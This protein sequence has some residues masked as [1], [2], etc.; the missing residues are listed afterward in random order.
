MSTQEI[1]QLRQAGRLD[2]AYA[3]AVAE[4]NAEPE[5]IWPKRNLS[6]VLYNQLDSL[7]K[8]LPKFLAKLEEL[9]ALDLPHDEV[10]FFENLSI[11]L[12]KSA[13]HIASQ[14]TVN[15]TDV[16]LLFNQIRELPLVKPSKWY[17][18][19]FQGMHKAFKDFDDYIEFADWW[20][21]DN[22]RPEDYEKDKLPDGREMMAL[23][24]QAYI[25][26]A[27]H[28]LPKHTIHGEI[29]FNKTKVEDFL[30]RLIQIS[31]DYPSYQYPP[32]Y[33]AKL[34]LA[35]GDKEN[36]LTALLPFA[37][38]KKND[39]WVWEILSETVP[40][41]EDMVF[42]LYCR[43]LNCYSP[44]EMLV[45]LRQKMA[46]LL[47]KRNLF[48]EARTEIELLVKSRLSKSFSIPSQVSHWQAEEWYKNAKCLKN[49]SRLYDEHKGKAEGLLYHDVEEEMAV[50]EFV[51]SDRKILNFIASESKYGF[52]KYERFLRNVE[53]G[54]IL[55]IR[56]QSGKIG[57][58]YKIHTAVKVDDH[59]FGDKYFKE[60]TGSVRKKDDNGFGFVNDIFIP[61]NVV[62]QN[63][64]QDNESV[65][66]K[67]IKSYNKKRNEFSWKVFEI[68]KI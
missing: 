6:W 34:L 22:F 28:L 66:A 67:A 3:M 42:A 54:D 13:R 26:Y 46:V 2:E 7:A 59:V 39:F 56:F 48:D 41:D 38:K 24:E 9:K 17:S 16:I 5:N 44:E 63:N 35:L 50:V 64:L 29:I 4:L 11:V 18:V 61:P 43:A 51:N 47:I 49:N 14:T 37:R 10:M 36:V 55:K 8:D 57:E 20:D 65:K 15:H 33:H 27:K 19:L 52:F 40:Q 23:A 62:S 32:Y 60:I 12:S 31:E 21:F 68:E 45:S 53:I 30:P 1:K 58:F 25:A